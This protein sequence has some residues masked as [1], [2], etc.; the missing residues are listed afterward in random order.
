MR[1]VDEFLLELE[2]TAVNTKDLGTLV[3]LTAIMLAALMVGF[4]DVHFN[5]HMWPG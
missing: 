5:T 3:L 1:M 4:L 2:G